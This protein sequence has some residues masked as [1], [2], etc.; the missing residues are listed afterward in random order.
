M[1]SDCQHNRI[2]LLLQLLQCQRCTDLHPTT[3]LHAHGGNDIDIPIEHLVREA[4]LWNTI[5]RHPS[6][7]TPGLIDHDP[8]PHTRQI[9]S[10]SQTGWPGPDYRHPLATGERHLMFLSDLFDP[11]MAHSIHHVTFEPTNRQRSTPPPNTAGILTAVST[12]PPTDV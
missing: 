10:R 8:M 11:T 1:E 7:S 2:V 9:P 5:A 3:D 6:R 12:D 4:I